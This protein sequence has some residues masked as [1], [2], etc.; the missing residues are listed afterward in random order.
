MP[1]VRKL[2]WTG[3]SDAGRAHRVLRNADCKV[4]PNGI[5][6]LF[7]DC[8]QRRP[9]V[10]E[11]VDRWPACI[12]ARAC[13]RHPL[14]L[15]YQV[16]DGLIHDDF[17]LRT[18]PDWVSCPTCVEW[19]AREGLQAQDEA[20]SG[21]SKPRK[22]ARHSRLATN[23]STRLAGMEDNLDIDSLKSRPAQGPT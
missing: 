5:K 16:S 11:R 10:R 15:F 18:P 13:D 14:Q 3:S 9:V 4:L 2:E 1:P 12:R 19:F 6:F 20:F 17:D 8:H 22:I 23:A 7:V 21:H